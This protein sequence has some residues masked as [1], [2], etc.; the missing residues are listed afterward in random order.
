MAQVI[1]TDG[2]LADIGRITDHIRRDSPR[3]AERIADRLIAAGDRLDEF[4]DVGR[5]IRS[6][7]REFRTVFPYVIRYRID[8]EVVTVLRVRHGARRP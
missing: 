3:A 4:P 2:A 6:P 1:W 7:L 8:G 5:A